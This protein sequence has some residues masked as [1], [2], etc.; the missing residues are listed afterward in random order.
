VLK[1]EQIAYAKDRALVQALIVKEK[2]P[3][4]F[5][6][7]RKLAFPWVETQKGRDRE[8]HIRILQEE[9]KKGVLTVT[10]VDG[11]KK[12]I[13]SRLRTR[14][15]ESESPSDGQRRGIDMKKINVKLGSVVPR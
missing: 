4:A 2:G 5:E 6:E 13:K 9:I 8:S 15:A 3:E 11:P 7:F 12:A 10:P 14:A 1:R